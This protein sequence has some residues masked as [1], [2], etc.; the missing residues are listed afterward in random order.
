MGWVSPTGFDDPDSEWT[1]ETL[2][3]DDDEGSYGIGKGD[4]YVELS[5][6]S[7]IN[8]EKCRLQV[9][10]DGTYNVD[11]HY[12]AD[13]HNIFHDTVTEAE[14]WKEITNVAGIKLVDKA[15]IKRDTSDAYVEEFDF[16]KDVTLATAAKR[17]MAAAF[18]PILKA[19]IPDG[20]ISAADREHIAWTYGGLAAPVGLG[21]YYMM[22]SSYGINI[23][24]AGQGRVQ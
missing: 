8:C 12:D 15:R 17:R 9:A 19:P 6:A 2:L 3:Y 14:G 10:L 23:Q 16:W 20:T 7:A 22:L 18:K 24:S 11:F 21:A 1:A 4:H 5:L 13:W